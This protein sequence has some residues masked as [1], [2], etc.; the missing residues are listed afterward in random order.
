QNNTIPIPYYSMC[1]SY[2]DRKSYLAKQQ[3]MEY[4]KKSKLSF[5]GN[6]GINFYL[7]EWLG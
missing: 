1:V 4:N 7:I 6:R 3:Q 5:N 2:I